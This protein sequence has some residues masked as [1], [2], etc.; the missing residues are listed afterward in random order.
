VAEPVAVEFS[1]AE[2]DQR[3]GLL[4]LW[5]SILGAGL[6]EADQACDRDWL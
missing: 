2:R 4:Q 3:E 1:A 5:G 6:G